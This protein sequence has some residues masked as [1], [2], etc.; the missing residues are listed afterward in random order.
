MFLHDVDPI[1]AAVGVRRRQRRRDIEADKA[2]LTLAVARLLTANTER[3]SLDELL[4]RFG[5]SREVLRDA[6][7]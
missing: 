2:D 6:D 5:Y 4:E 3:H 1:T 7:R